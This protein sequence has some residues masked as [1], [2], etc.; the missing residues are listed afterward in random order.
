[1]ADTVLLTGRCERRR[2]I[3]FHVRESGG[4]LVVEAPLYCAGRERE[5]WTPMRRPLE[6]GRASRYG[7]PCRATVLAADQQ[8][9]DRI[10]HGVRE[11][12]VTTT[13]IS[14]R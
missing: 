3:M 8:M 10:G 2:H 1:M 7:C 6:A 5:T 4:A 11:W 12:V 14:F 9:T 13:N